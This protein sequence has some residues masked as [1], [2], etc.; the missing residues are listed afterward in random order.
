MN[1][2]KTI[3][4]I[5]WKRI[6]IILLFTLVIVTKWS[7]YDYDFYFWFLIF[8]II[9]SIFFAVFNVIQIYKRTDL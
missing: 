7:E 1:K 6:G 5:E 9:V 2:L 8:S 3:F 4:A